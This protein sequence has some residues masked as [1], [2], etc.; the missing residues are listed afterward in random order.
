MPYRR[1]EGGRGKRDSRR[2]QNSFMDNG[3]NWKLRTN[4]SVDTSKFKAV[5]NTAKV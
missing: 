3:S 2:N 5:T 4:Y 1:D